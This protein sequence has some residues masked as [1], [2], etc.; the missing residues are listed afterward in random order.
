MIISKRKAVQRLALTWTFGFVILFGML[1]VQTMGNTYG[2]RPEE[3]WNWLLPTIMPTM[4]LIYGALFS[5]LTGEYFKTEFIKVFLY[6][7][8][9]WMSIFYL[10]IVSLHIIIPE[11]LY[12]P[13]LEHLSRSHIYMGPLQGLVG[14]TVGAFFANKIKKSNTNE[15]D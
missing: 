5:D 12:L 13:T 15:S 11:A 9:L 14:I 3:A 1:F 6:R 4:L 7:L 10:I 2:D 8:A